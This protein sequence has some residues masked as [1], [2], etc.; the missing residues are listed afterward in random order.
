MR[1]SVPM[2]LMTRMIVAIGVAIGLL[3]LSGVAAVAAGAEV[4]APA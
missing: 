4:A 3:A 2:R 1:A